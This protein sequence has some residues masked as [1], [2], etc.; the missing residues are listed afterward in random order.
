MEPFFFDSG[1]DKLFGVYHPAQ[2]VFSRKAVLLCPP[3]YAEYFRTY[4]YFR[5]LADSWSQAGHHV[6]RFDYFG[7]GDSAGSWRDAGPSRWLQDIEAASRELREISGCTQISLAGARFGATLALLSTCKLDIADRVIV[8]DPIVKG[9]DYINSLQDTHAR[10]LAKSNARA[11]A[12]L[13][14]LPEEL[15]G[16]RRESWVD[17]EFPMIDLSTLDT[18]NVSSVEYIA[19]DEALIDRGLVNNLTANCV[20]VNE[21]LCVDDCDWGTPSEVAMQASNVYEGLKRCL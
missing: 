4:R 15:A 9:A 10:L 16:F 1:G 2:D 3:I 19:S 6:L 20:E 21:S 17:D 12:L 14:G 8:W 18:R 5:N 7:T 13:T 11:R